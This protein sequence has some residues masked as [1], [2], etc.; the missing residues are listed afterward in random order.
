MK[1]NMSAQG[2]GI[3]SAHDK[4]QK[5]VQKASMIFLLLAHFIT[6]NTG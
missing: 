2:N 3:S 1:T 6:P 4:Q 5:D